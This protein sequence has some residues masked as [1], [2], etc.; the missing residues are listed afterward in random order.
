MSTGWYL[1]RGVQAGLLLSLL[2]GPLV[3]LLIQLSIRRGTAASLAAA[4]GIWTSDL[5]FILITHYGLGGLADYLSGTGGMRLIGTVG[6]LVLIVI[7]G[8]MWFRPPPSFKRARV[9]VERRQR[10]RGWAKAWLKGFAVNSLNPFTFF[11]WSTFVLTQVHEPNVPTVGALALYV[12]ILGTIV[13]TDLLK[14]L[15]ARHIRNFLQPHVLLRVQRVG[16]AALGFFG[17]VLILRVWF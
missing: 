10:N 6:A 2:V 14:V 16:A 5:L 4:A 12:G 8:V 15:L 7:G 17:L 9:Q 13:F 3:I 1:F 11:F